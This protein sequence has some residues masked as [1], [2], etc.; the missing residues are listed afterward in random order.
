MSTR[1]MRGRVLPRLGKVLAGVVVVA[2]AAGGGWWFGSRETGGAVEAAATTTTRT[3]AAS[4]DSLEKSVSATGTLTPAVQEDVS[5]TVNGTVASVDVAEGDT[6]TEGQT[7]ATIDSLELRAALLAARASLASA[8]ASLADAEDA[9]DDSDSADA[10]VASAQAQVEVAESK[11][12]D[13]TA[14]VAAA[15]LVAP[16]AGLLTSVDLEVGDVVSG[17]GSGGSAADASGGSTAAFTLISA[18]SWVVETTVDETDVALIA[19]GDQAELTV[20]GVTD[21]V[22]GTVSEIGLV[23]SATD[24]VAAYPVTIAVTGTTEDLHDGVSV[25]VEIVYER[26]TDVL[27]IPSTAV[28]TVDGESVV[29]V[30]DEAGTDTEVVVT[31]GETSGSSTEILSGLA[32]GD[33]VVVTVV[34]AQGGTDRTG[35]TTEDGQLPTGIDPNQVGGGTG[36]GS[37]TGPG[38]QGGNG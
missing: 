19:S 18:D 2:L 27:T 23:S 35:T 6:V 28:R 30:Q 37:G 17:S 1:S 38:G 9:D 32:E 21:T 12:E 7:L 11:V 3:V 14:D 26:R 20:D 15:T 16:V 5:F 8:E 31:T 4:L 24:G 29:T 33:T 13:A 22:F 34:T 25:E 36:P 10:R